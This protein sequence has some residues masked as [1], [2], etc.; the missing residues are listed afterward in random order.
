MSKQ[1]YYMYITDSPD[2]FWIESYTLYITTL[3]GFSEMLTVSSKFFKDQM[4]IDFKEITCFSLSPPDCNGNIKVS[5]TGVD[6]FGDTET[7]ERGLIPV[8]LFA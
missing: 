3:E 5:I 1:Q 8:N 2:Q 4:E 7:I 6:W